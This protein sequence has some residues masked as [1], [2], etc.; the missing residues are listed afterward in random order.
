MSAAFDAFTDEMAD[1]VLAKLGPK[2]IA[3]IEKHYAVKHDPLLTVAEVA[4]ELS[5][6]KD[7]VYELVHSERIKRA[8]GITEIRIRKSVVDAFGK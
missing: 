1:A 8:S 2:F 3:W 6:S 7:K 5:L 4:K